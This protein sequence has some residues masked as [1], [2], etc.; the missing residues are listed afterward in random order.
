MVWRAGKGDSW[1]VAFCL[2]WA[3]GWGV[4]RSLCDESRRI[5]IASSCLAVGPV[6]PRS[7]HP[8]SDQH[9]TPHTQPNPNNPNT[10]SVLEYILGNPR[11]N[12]AC[13]ANIA[14]MWLCGRCG[15]LCFDDH[16]LLVPPAQKKDRRNER[17][18]KRGQK[19][20]D[21]LN[22]IRV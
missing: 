9:R 14:F 10:L 7:V 20:L 2:G 8:S 4:V 11:S 22:R 12:S 18:T 16:P 17:R 19:K 5:G 1:Q 13:K 21:N 15:R 6:P 3:I